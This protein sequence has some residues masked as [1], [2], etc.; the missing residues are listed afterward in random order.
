MGRIPFFVFLELGLPVVKVGLRP[1]AESTGRT[2]VLMP[3]AAMHED[4]FAAR[5]KH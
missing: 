3:K 1:V 5:S 2:A 4:D